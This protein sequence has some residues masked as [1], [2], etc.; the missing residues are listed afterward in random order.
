MMVRRLETNVFAMSAEN[1]G[2]GALTTQGEGGSPKLDRHCKFGIAMTLKNPEN[3]PTRRARR[4]LLP[5][6]NGSKRAPTDPRP[7]Q[8]PTVD[9]CASN[10]VLN[11]TG[12][13]NST[14]VVAK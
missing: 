10:G 13:L 1:W 4:P 11:V 6:P 9:S 12:G 7:P 8:P 5:P 2:G 14:P 3:P